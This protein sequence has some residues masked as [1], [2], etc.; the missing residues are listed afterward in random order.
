MKSKTQRR[1]ISAYKTL[2]WRVIA[3]A[4]TFIISY[5]ITGRLLFATSIASI[6]IITKMCLYYWHERLWDKAR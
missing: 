4:D 5:I 6:E 3:T 1:K 2:T